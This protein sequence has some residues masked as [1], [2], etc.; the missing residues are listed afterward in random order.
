MKDGREGRSEEEKTEGRTRGKTIR[1]EEG[2]G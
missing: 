1:K 2:K